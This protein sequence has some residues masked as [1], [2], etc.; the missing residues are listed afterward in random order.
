MNHARIPEIIMSMENKII[1]TD[2]AKM[3]LPNQPK[4]ASIIIEVDN[5]E[6]PRPV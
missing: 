5:S 4:I 6:R 3:L 1:T 2:N